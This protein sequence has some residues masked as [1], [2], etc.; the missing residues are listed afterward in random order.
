VVWTKTF[1]KYRR[2]LLSSAMLGIKGRV[3][4]EGEVVHLVAHHL[5]DLTPLLASVGH[6][7]A[8]FPLPHGRGD[9]LHHGSPRPDPHGQAKV[10][11][12]HN[13]IDP[14]LHLDDLR[15]RTRD[16]R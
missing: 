9:E 8:P 11:A 14:Y 3:Q 15:V 13:I 4:R 16:F 12:A 5:T 6:R 2:V 1:E 10:P 7:D